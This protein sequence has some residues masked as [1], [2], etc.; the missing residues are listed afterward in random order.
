MN[1]EQDIRFMREAIL[2][3]EAAKGKTSPDPLVGAILV[4]NKKIISAGYHGE[5]TTPHAEAWAIEKAGR[6]ARGATL[7]VNLEPCCYFK[8]KNNPPCTE[9]IKKAGIKRVV[10]AMQDPNPRVKGRGF[11]ELKKAGIEVAVGILEQEAR[12]L[13]EV[14]IKYIKSGLPFVTIKA[15]MSLD[16]KIATK[17]GESFWISGLDSRKRVHYLRSINDAVMV[18]IGTVKKDDPEL[19]VRHVEGEEPLKI[20]LDPE[21]EIPQKAR[22]F[23]PAP[24]KTFIICSKKAPKERVERIKELG[25]EVICCPYKRSGGKMRLDLLYAMKE[26]GKKKVAS[27]LL[28]GGGGAIAGALQARIADKA[29][30][31]ISPKIIGGKDAPTPVEGEGIESLTQVIKLKDMGFEKVGEDIMVEGY[32][33][34]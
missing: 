14:F 25:A 33:D 20:V 34:Y 24:H 32:L 18:G 17:N 10:A 31:F 21:A 3:A 26:L 16:G 19:S 1:N 27:I 4:K 12:R 8:T 7:Y 9:L 5:V 22:L 30:F 11:K 15:A 13:N 23:K 2:I 29:V 6:E 28:E